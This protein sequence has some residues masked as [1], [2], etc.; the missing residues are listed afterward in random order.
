MP[1]VIDKLKTLGHDVSGL[2]CKSWDEFNGADAPHM[3]FVI[4]LCDTLHGQDCP[5]VGDQPVTASWPLPDPAKFKGT[6]V[7]GAPPGSTISTGMIPPA[8]CGVSSS[9]CPARTRSRIALKK[10]LDERGR[11][12]AGAGMTAG[13]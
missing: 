11:Q 4:T 12:P 2:R 6:P 7:V 5:D 10:R 8:G 1:E 9:T 3:D 13:A